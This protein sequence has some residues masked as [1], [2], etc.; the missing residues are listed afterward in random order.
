MSDNLRQYASPREFAEAIKRQLFQEVMM[1]AD[2]S[3]RRSVLAGFYGEKV[4]ENYND[5]FDALNT[6]YHRVVQV[7]VND[8]YNTLPADIRQNFEEHFYFS[9]I[10]NNKIDASI[11]R[12]EDN[13]FFAVFLNSSLIEL[14]VKLGK[15]DTARNNPECVH[16]CS[17]FPDSKP[18][19]EDLTRM[20]Y[21]TVVLFSTR[22]LASGPFLVLK[23][24]H[25]HH[26]M[27]QLL[28]KE[29]F[30]LYHEIAHFLNG[31]LFADAGK[32]P[33][34][35]Q[36]LNISYQEEFLADLG[37][38]SLLLL[39][40]K[41]TVLHD[42]RL[43]I[44]YALFDLFQTIHGLQGIETTHYPHP[45]N[46]LCFILTVFYGKAFADL[47]EKALRNNDMKCL[48]PELLPEIDHSAEEEMTSRYAD[49][50]IR[51]FDKSH[52]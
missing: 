36:F 27:G 16:F 10:D 11:R 31:D 19:K 45:L 48:A 37:A 18:T 47:A 52:W 29:K 39:E 17:R 5:K 15:L 26:H 9:T 49:L 28:I 38:L 14:L 46:R 32:R 2:I 20:Y 44:F 40:K 41:G 34:T 22:K 35:P 25:S 13:R 23:E 42:E 21:E 4:F 12:S 24:P 6:R 8:F 50:M 1:A 30:I 33:L 51:A 7:L 43:L 3:T